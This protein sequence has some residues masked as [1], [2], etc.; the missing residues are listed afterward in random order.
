[1][2]MVGDNNAEATEQPAQVPPGTF[3]AF[4]PNQA[5]DGDEDGGLLYR[6]ARHQREEE[7]PSDTTT[8]GMEGSEDNAANWTRPESG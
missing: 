7:G 3:Q 6:Q 4:Q 2:G 1:M 5:E 8:R